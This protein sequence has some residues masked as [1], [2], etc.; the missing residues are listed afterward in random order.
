MVKLYRNNRQ[1]SL[2]IKELTQLKKNFNIG[3]IGAGLVGERLIN[4][5]IRN[6]RGTIKGINDVN[7]VRLKEVVDKYDLVAVKSYHELLNDQ[8]IDMIYLAVPPKYH[9]P[10]ARDI[11]DSKKHFLCEKPLANSTEEAKEMYEGVTQNNLVNGMNFPTAYT[12]AFKEMQRLLEAGFIGELLR[13]ELKG[14]FTHWPRLWQ[15]NDWIAT[16]EQGGFVKEV[17]THF[18]QIIQRFFGEIQDIHSCIEYPEASDQ[19]EKGIIA[20]GK[21]KGD[22]PVLFN[23]LTDVGMKEELAFTIYGDQGTISLRDWHELWTSTK[24]TN[25]EKVALDSNDHL[26]DL[27]DELFKAIEGKD[28][29]LVTFK[30]GYQAQKVIDQL[31]KNN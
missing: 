31:L 4:A 27:L 26:V 1:K 3:I 6:P 10:I 23:G 18:I 7:E 15:Q 11:I 30:E 5:I 19:S 2:L 21:V 22:I 16:K 14:A 24:E 29:N 8:E 9:F 12:P 20:L 13:I 28:A 25:L 17:F